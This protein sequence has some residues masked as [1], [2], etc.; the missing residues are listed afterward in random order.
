MERYFSI[1]E[2]VVIFSLAPVFLHGL[3]GNLRTRACFLVFSHGWSCS[4]SSAAT[5]ALRDAVRRSSFPPACR[6]SQNQ[7]SDNLMKWCQGCGVTLFAQ[8]LSRPLF[9]HGKGVI[10][11]SVLCRGTT[12]N[13][14][15]CIRILWSQHAPFRPV[16]PAR[17]IWNKNAAFPW[18]DEAAHQCEYCRGH[19]KFWTEVLSHAP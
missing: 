12:M 18:Q 19:Y 14:D 15:L 1:I 6:S 5:D 7:T 10:F 3:L 8:N 11:V 9:L 16:G 2:D 17:N 13:L 4:S